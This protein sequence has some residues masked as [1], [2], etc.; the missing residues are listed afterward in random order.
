MSN[1]KKSI[2]ST[3]NFGSKFGYIMVAAGAAIGL[4]NIWRFPY[5]AYGNGGGTFIL[6]YIIIAIV[7]AYPGVISEEAIGRATRGNAVTSF[8]MLN[9]KWGFAGWIMA[10]TTLLIDFYYLIVSG[11]V[12]KYTLAYA[13]AVFTGGTVGGADKVAY[14][15]NFIS[16]PVEP[17]IYG[18][19]MIAAT[20]LVLIFGITDLAEKI[21]KVIMPGLILLLI[22]CGIWA[23]SISPEARMGLKWYVLPD[24]SKLNMRTFAD[25]CMQILF[26]VGI[27]WA[28]F[29][30]LGASLPDSSNMR[31]DA[32]WV[33]LLDSSVA[34]LA[35]FVI[36][37]SVVGSGSELTSGPSLVFLSMTTIFEKFPGG[38]LIGLAF[39]MALVFAVFSTAFTIVEIPI[40]VVREKYNVEPVKA[41]V[42]V[43][44]IIAVFGT[45]CAWSQGHGILSHALLPW[46]DA[47][48]VSYY[49]I[50]DWVDLLSAYVG[51]PLGTL[52][53]FIFVSRVWGYDNMNKELIKGGGKPISTWDKVTIGYLAPFCVIVVILHAFGIWDA[54]GLV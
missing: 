43:S 9:K 11:Y 21:C 19:F 14:Y 22:I 17:L 54:L 2:H 12:I 38:T 42:I 26:S 33:V 23:V 34:L 6:V 13:K 37:P 32:K 16:D 39:F 50:Y 20:G 51:L 29:I 41:V 7:L 49:C 46:L 30:T 48:G 25:A 35:G 24:F 47:T 1:K 40:K 27:G 44:A 3:E 31:S 45:L 52:L 28:I 5:I 8:E 15:Q 10:I 4:G 36:I 18:F 53:C